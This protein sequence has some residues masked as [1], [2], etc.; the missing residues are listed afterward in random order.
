MAKY[1]VVF[2]GSDVA[3][4]AALDYPSTFLRQVP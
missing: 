2:N 1:R 3:D 4:G